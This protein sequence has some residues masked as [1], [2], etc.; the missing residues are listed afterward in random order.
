MGAHHD[1]SVNNRVPSWHGDHLCGDDHLLDRPQSLVKHSLRHSLRARAVWL[2][3]TLVAVSGIAHGWDQSG[4]YL[5]RTYA[6]IVSRYP[7]VMAANLARAG[8]A[9]RVAHSHLQTSAGYPPGV[10]CPILVYTGRGTREEGV[11]WICT[12]VGTLFDEFI[13]SP[14]CNGGAKCA[15]DETLVF[16]AKHKQT[17]PPVTQIGWWNLII[18]LG[19]F[20]A[21]ITQNAYIWCSQTP[22]CINSIGNVCSFDEVTACSTPMTTVLNGIDQ[23]QTTATSGSPGDPT[24][25]TAMWDLG[26]W[27]RVLGED[28]GSYIYIDSFDAQFGFGSWGVLTEEEAC[29]NPG[30]C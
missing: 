30:D 16:L 22:E 25:D 9:G 14:A 8:T 2:G 20:A 11:D 19:H 24:V 17:V 21:T 13:T 1:E 12:E 29:V 10:H 28:F 18:S 6:D 4:A 5:G 26:Y 7:S 3:L 27:E 23:A 15:M